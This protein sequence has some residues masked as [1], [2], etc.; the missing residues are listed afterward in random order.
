MYFASLLADIKWQSGSVPGQGEAPVS[1]AGLNILIQWG[2]M[3]GASPRKP[4]ERQLAIATKLALALE[5]LLSPLAVRTI[6]PIP[7]VTPEP[8]A[9]PTAKPTPK[10]TAKPKVTP[11][12]TKKP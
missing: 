9:A 7:G 2:P 10:P 6:V 8:T 5:P 1:I 12:P 11:K 4:D 3:T